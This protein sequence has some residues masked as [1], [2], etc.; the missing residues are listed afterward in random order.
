MN[1]NDAAG[2]AHE[3]FDPDAAADDG[4][5]HRAD[6]LTSPIG[7]DLQVRA[8]VVAGAGHVEGGRF[9]ARARVVDLPGAVVESNRFRVSIRTDSSPGGLP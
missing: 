5:G 8:R 6:T 1:A 4:L 7:P 2:D 3:A 9:R